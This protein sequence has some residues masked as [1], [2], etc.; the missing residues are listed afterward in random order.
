MSYTPFAHT[1]SLRIGTVDYVAPD[2]LQVL[3]D[4]KAPE[5]VAL[6]SGSVHPF[7][8]VNGYVLIPVDDSHL[9]GQVKSMTVEQSAF[10]QRKGKTDSSLIDLPYPSRKMMLN[11]VGN[12][13]KEKES[14]YNFRRGADA[15]PSVGAPVLLPTEQQLLSIVQSGKHQRVHIGT[16]PLAAN[17]DVWVD[18]DR[19]FG[20]HLAV[21]GNT[22]S[23]KSCSV[24]GLIRWSLE[25]ARKSR[26]SN[27]KANGNRGLNARFIVLDPNGEYSRAFPSNDT[28][29][30]VKTFK[31]NPES[32]EY[33]LKVPVW[34]WNSTEWISFTQAS[35]KAQQ[36]VLIQALRNAQS[37]QDSAL[38][39]KTY[40]VI[41][42]L[43]TNART[44]ENEK[45]A[46]TPWDTF[47]K[48]KGFYTKVENYQ[49]QL[50]AD[51]KTLPSTEQPKLQPLVDLV[52]K[53]YR[54]H[55]GKDP[56]YPEYDFTPDEV[57]DLIK[58]THV[59]CEELGGSVADAKHLD[60]DAPTPFTIDSFVRHVKV[61]AQ[62][63]SVTEYVDTL[64][65]RIQ[66]R[67]GDN[68]IKQIIDG[69]GDD[70]G[71]WL[72][73]FTDNGDGERQVTIL[74]LSFVPSEIVHV[75]TAVVARVIFEALQRY[76][77]RHG[78]VTLP[79]VLVMEEAHTFIRR[80]NED[81]EIDSMASI[82]CQVFE[83]IA[84]EG[85][86]YGLG[87]VLSS[88]RPSDLS[89]TVIAQ[90]NTFLLHRISNSRDQDLVG[91]LLPDS[92]SGVL[93]ELPLLPAQH[94]ILLGWASELP[95]LVKM[96]KLPKSQQP[97]SDDPAYWNV[98][99]NLDP[100]S[101]NR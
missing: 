51:L 63:L 93:D 85:R 24:A 14:K 50:V 7:P 11:P 97:L 68:R 32:G 9:V 82:C 47:P 98:W 77:K 18:P 64:L 75:I 34:L 10:P 17:A 12:L 91:R 8:R 42:Y 2:K 22:G 57:N 56:N 6:N 66:N 58:A 13:R 45:I 59:A 83:R 100:D 15:L 76:R 19:L 31:V 62:M 28:T 55:S 46:G 54:A 89:P 70:L 40:D 84:R 23:G 25:A 61:A 78:G 90:C 26:L 81:A 60:A 29:V 80:Y 37:G 96:K 33:Q 49:R 92:I 43:K 67:F 5:S 36:P 79:T 44:I 86:K 1:E 65:M 53:I 38:D 20:R 72:N 48:N 101:Q 95:V 4:R 39:G 16:S 74:D 52:T 71:S 99:T 73:D 41:R 27:S 88:Q 30:Q 35:A 87:L 3:L 69:S 21:L 94:A